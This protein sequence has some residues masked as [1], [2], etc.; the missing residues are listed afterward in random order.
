[1]DNRAG[2]DFTHSINYD[3]LGL[4]F[5]YNPIMKGGRLFVDHSLGFIINRSNL[6]LKIVLYL[7]IEVP[8]DTVLFL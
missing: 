5:H 1:M 7:P 8:E 6:I 3:L 4:I 2:M